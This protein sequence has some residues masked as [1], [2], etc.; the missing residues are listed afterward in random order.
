MKRTKEQKWILIVAVA[1][2]LMML[3]VPIS[4]IFS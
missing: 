3:I 1:I 4:M 2:V